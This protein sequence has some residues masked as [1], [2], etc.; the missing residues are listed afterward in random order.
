MGSNPFSSPE[1][2]SERL[3]VAPKSST[4]VRAKLRPIGLLV[5]GAKLIGDRYWL[6]VGITLLGILAGTAVPLG[7]LYGAMICGIYKCL[8]GKAR[9]EELELGMVFR[10][11]DFIWRSFA[12]MLIQGGFIVAIWVMVTLLMTAIRA[13]EGNGEGDTALGFAIIGAFTIIN[14]GVSFLASFAW[15][16]IADRGCDAIDALSA[17]VSATFKNFAALAVHHA[18]VVVIGC[19]TIVLCYVPF[20]LFLPIVFAANAV[21]FQRI[22]PEGDADTEGAVVGAG[23]IADG[24][25]DDGELR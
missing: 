11:V 9:G 20:L 16:L 15:P 8:L 25:V 19:V 23:V 3:E 12:V 21:A 13:P 24:P 6:F 18:I 1:A 22:F 7:L 14:L 5:D 10:G 17:S 2:A 4:P